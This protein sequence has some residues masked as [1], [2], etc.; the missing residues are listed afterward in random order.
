[1]GAHVGLK[2]VHAGLGRAIQLH[3]RVVSANASGGRRKDGPGMGIE[4]EELYGDDAAVLAE[5]LKRLSLDPS[6]E[7]SVARDEPRRRRRHRRARVPNLFAHVRGAGLEIRGA[8][9]AN[10]SLGGAF[11]SCARECAIGTALEVD[12]VASVPLRLTG[13]IV[14]SVSPA[15]ALSL[16]T[17][18]GFSVRFGPMP[19]AS[20]KRLRDLMAHMAP[21]LATE[22]L[23]APAATELLADE[24]TPARSPG[25]RDLE[26]FIQLEEPPAPPRV[27]AQRKPE[28]AP[29]IHAEIRRLRAEIEERQ[30]RI[31]QLELELASALGSSVMLLKGTESGARLDVDGL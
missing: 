29:P 13:H 9:V 25:T 6:P 2:L 21:G 4:F 7:P 15:E 28:S 1:V 11:V 14:G 16:G 12:L 20:L 19:N 17:T 27:E 22:I 8:T 5:L 30:L 31:A 26:V 3:G 10:L 24:P 18:P 23:S